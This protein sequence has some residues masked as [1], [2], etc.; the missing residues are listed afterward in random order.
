M[1]NLLLYTL[2][3]LILGHS[4]GQAFKK[5]ASL[6]KVNESRFYKILLTPEI[7]THLNDDLSDIRIYD[8]TQKEIPYILSREVPLQ[9]H[10]IFKEYNI[11]EYKSQSKCCSKLILQNTAKNK[12]D[13][14][15]LIIK[16]SD[17]RKKAKLSGSSDNKLWYIIKDDYHLESYPSANNTSEVKILNFP[18]L[19]YEYYMLEIGDSGS[20]P[21][22][23]LKAGYYDSYTQKGK[24]IELP[25]AHVH[26]KDSS[27]KKSYISISFPSAQLIDKIKITALEPHYYF[28]NTAICT[29]YYQKGKKHYNTI[30]ET[31]LR[32]N[33][34]NIIEFDHLK[35]KDFQLII[36]NQDNQPL[37]IKNI[38]SY[39]LVYYMTAMLEKGKAYTLQ[40]GDKKLSYPQYDLGYFKDSI[41]KNLSIINVGAIHDIPQQIETPEKTF[42]SSMLWVWVTIFLI[43]TGLGYMSY[44]M[45]KEMKTRQT[46]DL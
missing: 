7:V 30:T 34:D 21:L 45:I 15:S 32:S 4:Y 35:V 27:D 10:Q 11:K 12:I 20:A 25:R 3:F 31:T 40:F 22:N 42:F 38:E 14:I 41:P 37:K 28:R 5:K 26:R 6:S 44:K 16:N 46:T 39:Q 13:N 33:S 43:M 17:V 23:I 19:D 2:F 1:K 9:V 18:L 24:F 8:N 36:E 29:T